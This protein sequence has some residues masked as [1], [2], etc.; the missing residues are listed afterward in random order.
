VQA[1]RFSFKAM[2]S[3][4]E[5][6]LYAESPPRIDETAREAMAEIARLEQKYSRYRDDSLATRINR[7]AG[8]PNGI[9][10][11]AET[12]ALLDYAEIAWRESGG[13]FD[14]TSGVLRRVW[15]FRSG[16]VPEQAEIDALRPLLGWDKL[17]WQR[18]HLRLPLAGMELDFGGYVKEYAADRVAERCRELGARHGLVDLGGD[19]A[20][21]GPHPDGSPWRVGIRNPRAQ[22]GA[23][24]SVAL[25]AGG[26]ATSGDYERCMTVGGRR[27]AHVLDPRTGW[28]VEGLAS[29]TVA[30][31]HCLV[32]GTASTVAMLKGRR[33][34]LAWLDRLGLPSLR[35]DASGAVSGSLARGAHAHAAARDSVSA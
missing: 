29:V 14:I 22:Q 4:C 35:V 5:L 19:L 24:A 16:R 11:D 20:V 9:E 30:A 26:I 32:A 34:G 27:Y 25:A 10:L 23:I 31:G 13:L 2:G 17:L 12:A 7:S 6:H 33:H 8:D 3:P 28:P 21:I 18:P 15:N 1:Q